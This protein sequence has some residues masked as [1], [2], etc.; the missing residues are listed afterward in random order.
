[1]KQHVFR[2]GRIA[3]DSVFT[4][5]SGRSKQHLSLGADASR[6]ALGV[7]SPS[8]KVYTLAIS[9]WA[10]LPMP[11]GWRKVVAAWSGIVNGLVF[12]VG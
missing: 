9:A 8:S 6:N 4:E 10:L 12:H 3:F 11:L 5:F 7:L 2:S 1:M